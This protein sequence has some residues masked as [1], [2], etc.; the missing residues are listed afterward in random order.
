M[1]NLERDKKKNVTRL[2][3]YSRTQHQKEMIDVMG[4]NK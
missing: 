3:S 1:S 4:D 2:D